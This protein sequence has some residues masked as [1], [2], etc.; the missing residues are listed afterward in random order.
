ME[1][2]V[3]KVMKQSH[4]LG[5]AGGVSL[6]Q[7]TSQHEVIRALVHALVIC[8]SAC[9]GIA[10]CTSGVSKGILGLGS[11]FMGS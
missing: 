2:C 10:L 6:S 8:R 3:L 4:F 11:D 9:W 7:L 5:Y 1:I